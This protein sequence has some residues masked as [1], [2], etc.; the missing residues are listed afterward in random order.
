M[1]VFREDVVRRGSTAAIVE[2]EGLRGFAIRNVI[3]PVLTVAGWGV[4]PMDVLL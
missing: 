4:D 1:L 2:N 3:V